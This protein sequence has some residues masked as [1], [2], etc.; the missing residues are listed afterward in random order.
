MSLVTKYIEMKSDTVI[1]SSEEG[2]NMINFM[3]RNGKNSE[4]LLERTPW[5]VFPYLVA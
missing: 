3:Y 5:W 2:S 1:K 4:N